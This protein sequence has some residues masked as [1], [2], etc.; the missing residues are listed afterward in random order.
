MGDTEDGGRLSCVLVETKSL[1][2]STRCGFRRPAV[3]ELAHPQQA[4]LKLHEE[5]W[6]GLLQDQG[7]RISREVEIVPGCAVLVARP[8]CPEH[9][10]ELPGP[11]RVIRNLMGWTLEEKTAGSDV[12]LFR[13]PLEGEDSLFFPLRSGRLGKEGVVPHS[14]VGPL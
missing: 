9:S 6:A 5:A 1:S 8:S 3:D 13:G 12:W 14:V 11:G 10:P 7:L 4:P 2:T